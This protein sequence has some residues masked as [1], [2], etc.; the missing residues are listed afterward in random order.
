MPDYSNQIAAYDQSLSPCSLVCMDAEEPDAPRS[1]RANLF[2]LSRPFRISEPSSCILGRHFSGN[3]ALPKMYHVTSVDQ[4]WSLNWKNVYFLYILR[5]CL[6]LAS[7]IGL[8][9]SDRFGGVLSFLR[10]GDQC[11]GMIGHLFGS[12]L[13]PLYHIVGCVSFSYGVP[14]PSRVFLPPE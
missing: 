12:S 5:E 10:H 4:S 2:L 8:M 14:F 11:D 6:E 1:L 13:H 7:Y 9:K 3:R